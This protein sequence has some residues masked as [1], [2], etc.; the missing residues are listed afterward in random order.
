MEL[1]SNV[2]DN[3]EQSSTNVYIC[4]TVYIQH[5]ALR[6]QFLIILLLERQKQNPSN[7]K[8]NDANKRVKLRIFEKNGLSVFFLYKKRTINWSPKFYSLPKKTRKTTAETTTTNTIIVN[9]K[10]T[11]CL[12]KIDVGCIYLSRGSIANV[13]RTVPLI[14]KSNRPTVAIKP[15]IFIHRQKTYTSRPMKA[16]LKQNISSYIYV[17]A[18]LR[19]TRPNR[20]WQRVYSNSVRIETER[21]DTKYAIL[22]MIMMD[23]TNKHTH[24]ENKI[25]INWK[26]LCA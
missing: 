20:H 13:A 6:I 12:L 5:S 21:I 22:K 17:V 23:E 19:Q 15:K 8:T 11:F 14:A 3:T 4:N 10:F 2:N 7:D 16:I 25:K 24:T 26:F 1:G 9:W 18:I